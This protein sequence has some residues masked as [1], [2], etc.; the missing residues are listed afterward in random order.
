MSNAISLDNQTFLT[1]WVD[2]WGFRGMGPGGVS[3]WEGQPVGAQLTLVQ[4]VCL[5]KQ[6]NPSEAF[7]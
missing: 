7:F 2:S 1:W 6:F 3:L 5:K 4:F